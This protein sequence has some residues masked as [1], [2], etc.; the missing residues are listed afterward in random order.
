MSG[1]RVL[2]AFAAI[3]VVALVLGVLTAAT[4]DRAY[5]L[6]RPV[7]QDVLAQ[8]SRLGVPRLQ[9]DPDRGL[10]IVD[11]DKSGPAAAAGMV[12]GDILQVVNDTPVDTLADLKQVLSDLHPGDEITVTVLH[13]DELKQ[14]TVVLGDRKGYPYLGIAPYPAPRSRYVR[15]PPVQTAPGEPGVTI[16]EVAEGSPA[17]RAGLEAGDRIVAVDDVPVDAEHPLPEL[18]GRYRP[19]DTVTLTVERIAGGREK[20][21]VRLGE[22]PERMGVTYLGIRYVPGLTTSHPKTPEQPEGAQPF[23]GPFAFP[24]APEELP[25]ELPVHPRAN[26]K[27]DELLRRF[28]VETVVKGVVADSPAAEAG[29]QPGDRIL[30]V[31]DEPV[32]SPDDVVRIVQSH[33]PGDVI[34]LKLQGAD[35]KEPREVEVRLAEHPDRPGVAYLGVQLG[36]AF[37]LDFDG[38]RGQKGW[39]R[40]KLPLDKEG[41]GLPFQLPLDK[42]KHFFDFL[43]PPTF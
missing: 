43:N 7:L 41:K 42:F 13:G 9:P 35:D 19:G 5:A 40:F 30:A 8:A 20:I 22:H 31:D 1:K 11:I 28:H 21:D 27:L 17:A 33:E 29:M 25:F 39:Y 3:T 16:I 14:L 37:P 36:M 32:A 26:P 6:A 10:V 4:A 24:F 2:K 23:F 12:R 18:I 38:Q 15:K 34:R